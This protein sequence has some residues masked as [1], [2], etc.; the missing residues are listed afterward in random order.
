M[1]KIGIQSLGILAAAFIF[2]HS[3]NAATPVSGGIKSR[4]SSNSI[5]VIVGLLRERIINQYKTAGHTQILASII[6]KNK[7]IPIQTLK[8]DSLTGISDVKIK[9][10][11]AGG[12]EIITN[13]TPISAACTVDAEALIRVTYLP[14]GATQRKSVTSVQKI[15][16]AGSFK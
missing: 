9:G 16:L 1:K 15:S 13:G 10:D 2:T 12:T 14:S 6:V 7:V 5:R 4:C 3:A 8:L 11:V